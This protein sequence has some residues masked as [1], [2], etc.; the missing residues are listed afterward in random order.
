MKV[1]D[2]GLA[3]AWQPEEIGRSLIALSPHHHCT[4]DTRAGTSCWAPRPT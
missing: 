4:D 3:K 2:F 1:L